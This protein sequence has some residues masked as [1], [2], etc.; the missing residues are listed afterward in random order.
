MSIPAHIRKAI[1]EIALAESIKAQ[2]EATLREYYREVG[3]F[4][5]DGLFIDERRSK[6]EAYDLHLF[7]KGIR[8]LHGDDAEQEWLG[9]LISSISAKDSGKHIYSTPEEIR[10]SVLTWMEQEDEDGG[11]YEGYGKWTLGIRKSAVDE[12][13]NELRINDEV[14]PESK[15]QG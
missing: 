11:R 4:D 3:P 14:Q 13:K 15:D 9:N 8:E 6:Y 2:N 1:E 7:R 10:E 12:D 5:F